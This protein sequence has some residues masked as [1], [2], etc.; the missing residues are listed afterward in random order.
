[1]RRIIKIILVVGIIV[2][3]CALLLEELRTRP[4][5]N[6]PPNIP[7]DNFDIA[8]A[9]GGSE[10]NI[11]LSSKIWTTEELENLGIFIPKDPPPKD[12]PVSE[13]FEIGAKGDVTEYTEYI[14]AGIYAGGWWGKDYIYRGLSCKIYYPSCKPEWTTE[15]KSNIYF[16]IVIPHLVREDGFYIAVGVGWSWLESPL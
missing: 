11:D 3:V 6:P 15:I 7:F 16:D 10:E 12:F 8:M 14:Q 13:N 9:F 4:P 5:K 1:M 2:V